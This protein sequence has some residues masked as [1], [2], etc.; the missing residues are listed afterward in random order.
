[1]LRG[2]KQKT[3]RGRKVNDGDRA[4]CSLTSLRRYGNVQF[5]AIARVYYAMMLADLI[6]YLDFLL[7]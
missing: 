7:W 2:R 1:M 6:D 3:L 5:R 4:S